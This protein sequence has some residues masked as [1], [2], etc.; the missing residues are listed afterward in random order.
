MYTKMNATRAYVYAT[1]RA[2]D[3]KQSSRKA[4]ARGCQSRFFLNELGFCCVRQ[5]C[6]GVILYAAERATEVALDAIQLL[7][8]CLP[9]ATVSFTPFFQEETATS[10]TIQ[11]VASCVTR[12]YMKSVPAQ[13]RFGGCL[14]DA[15]SSRRPPTETKQQKKK[16]YVHDVPVFPLIVP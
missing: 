7:G 11:R 13:A 2:C 3:M 9:S 5:D 6:A 16:R 15:S 4:R 12:N 8:A 1:A 10:T 14:S